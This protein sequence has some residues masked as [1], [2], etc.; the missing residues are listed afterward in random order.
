MK[1]LL[2]ALGLGFACLL[3][4]CQAPD[5]SQTPTSLPPV[6][7]YFSPKGGCTDAVVKELNAAKTC[8]LG[9]TYH[10]SAPG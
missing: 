3:P 6:Q 9:P 2:L 1:R 5:I 7:V 8:V 4:G 10:R